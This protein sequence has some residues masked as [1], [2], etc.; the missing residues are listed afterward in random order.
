MKTAM[1][2]INN[3]NLINKPMRIVTTLLVGMLALAVGHSLVAQE[4]FNKAMG[5]QLESDVADL[6]ARS[7][8]PGASVAIVQN[9]RVV[10]AQ[11][12]GVREKGKPDRVTPE[13]LMMIGSTGKSMTTMMMATLVDQGKIRWDTPA[14]EVYP[15]FAV[16]DPALT[17][18][19]TLRNTVCNCTG[20]QRH[21]LEMQFASRPRTPEGVIRSLRNLRF[22]GTFGKTFGYV[23]QMVASG[24]YIAAWAARE[25][26]QPL[27][28]TY[29]NQMQRNVFDPIGMQ[30]TTFSFKRALANPNHAIPHGQNGAGEYV[31]IPLDMEKIAAPFAPAGASWSTA[32]DAARYL[33]TQLN[34]G[35]A[36][37]GK[38][39]VSTET[40]TETWKP[41]VEIQPGIDYGLGWMTGSH[42]GQRLLSHSGGTEGF[43]SE[44]TFMPD[45]GLGIV[46]LTNA[47]NANLFTAGV[48]SRIIELVFG[49]PADTTYSSRLEEARK[50]FDQK[51]ATVRPADERA[52]APYF[53]RYQNP[54]L[55]DVTLKVS[56][57]KLMLNIPGFPTEL[58]TLDNETYL[59][60]DPPLAGA[61]IRLSKNANS[62]P[63][64]VLHAESLDIPEEY[65]FSRTK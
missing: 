31:P 26:G 37:N 22:T 63:T 20:I 28:E 49:Q 60:W 29:L 57:G 42:K 11:G 4:L 39:V 43:T 38:R 50:S 27:Y 56:G 3:M 47:Q 5:R 10:Y 25:P 7:Q 59:F 62:K 51:K 40:L 9:G 44:L 17:S 14:A 55:G 13:S 12:F 35:I 54:S 15:D 46:V 53:G 21:D 61:L 52:A 48:R 1:N 30:E 32:R 34:Q 24:G 19:I 58:R 65:T 45:A 64:F 36:P 18:K 41:Q 8:V 2:S 33:I 6:M 16:S 23:N